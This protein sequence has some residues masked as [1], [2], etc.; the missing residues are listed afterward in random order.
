[1][2][3][4]GHAGDTAE[5]HNS[6]TGRATTLYYTLRRLRRRNRHGRNVWHR[7]FQFGQRIW[8][9]YR[10]FEQGR[11]GYGHFFDSPSNDS[12]LPAYADY[13]A[14]G[15]QFAELRGTR[16]FQLG[17]GFATNVGI[18]VN[19]GSDTA[20]LYASSSNDT[21]FVYAD[22]G[23]QSLAG[24]HDASYSYSNYA[25]GFAANNGYAAGG[26]GGTAE[27][28]DAP[29]TNTFSAYGNYPASGLPYAGMQGTGY[30]NAASGFSV[31]LAYRVNGSNDTAEFYDTST[32]SNNHYYS[33][34]NYNQSGNAEAGMYGSGYSN[35]A[36]GFGASA[37]VPFNGP[38]PASPANSPSDQ[39]LYTDLAIAQLYGS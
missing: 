36:S 11:Q 30:T 27:F 28:F 29:G 38:G 31:N 21:F 26:G 2:I 10:K 5:F 6:T 17:Q 8:N 25:I 12:L 7:L 13:E 32:P 23:G 35:S 16:R 37:E 39:R 1:M 4:T 19:G 18:V 24:M 3:A 20:N 34:A 33:F 9:E 22:Q 14:A 15:K